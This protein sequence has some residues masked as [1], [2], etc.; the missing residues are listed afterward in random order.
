MPTA[1]KIGP[2]TNTGHL[3]QTAQHSLVEVDYKGLMAD[4]ARLSLHSDSG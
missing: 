4:N 2:D 3:T 1:G